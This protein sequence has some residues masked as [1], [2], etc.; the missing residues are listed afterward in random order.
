MEAITG[1]LFILFVLAFIKPNAQVFNKV[2][3]LKDK[4]N[5]V[6][7][8]CFFVLWLVLSSILVLAF[9]EREP[10][11]TQNSSRTEKQASEY[12]IIDDSTG[13][14]LM[15]KDTLRFG[16]NGCIEW[17]AAG[18]KQGATAYIKVTLS[19][20]IGIYPAKASMKLGNIPQNGLFHLGYK[21]YSGEYTAIGLY[22]CKDENDDKCTTKVGRTDCDS[23]VIK[24]KDYSLLQTAIE[25]DYKTQIKPLDLYDIKDF[26][27]SVIFCAQGVEANNSRDG[28][29]EYTITRDDEVFNIIINGIFPN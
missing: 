8:I 11:E 4:S 27:D 20:P 29:R 13:V 21:L 19:E 25:R 3:F 16:K 28:K 5:T 24:Q 18:M 6:R 23:R 17:T 10:S 22:T 12:V 7:R 26:V 2:S 15:D 9:G 1:L 14:I